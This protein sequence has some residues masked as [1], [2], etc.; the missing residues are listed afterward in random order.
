MAQIG[1]AHGIKGEVRVKPFGEDPLALGSYGPLETQDGSRRFEV[2]TL[3]AQKAMLIVRFKGV[4]DRNAAEA[5]NGINLFLSRDVLPEPEDE[6]T[7]YQADLI[8][9]EVVDVQGNALGGVVSVQDF[10]AG[11]LLEIASKGGRSFYIPFTLEVVPEIDLEAGR[12]VVDPPE[13][14]MADAE[15]DKAEARAE[16]QALE[17]TEQEASQGREA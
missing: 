6:D 14:L 5:L 17:R 10:G 1:A 8:G 12:V 11:D 15:R 9:L 16:Q 13:G 7:F 4:G 2:E 3:R